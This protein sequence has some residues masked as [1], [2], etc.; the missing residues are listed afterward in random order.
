M[1]GRVKNIIISNQRLTENSRWGSDD[2]RNLFTILHV[3]FQSPDI[4]VL[5]GLVCQALNREKSSGP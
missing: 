1:R 3:C 5:A 4:R 2:S